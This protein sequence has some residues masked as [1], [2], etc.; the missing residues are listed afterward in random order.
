MAKTKPTLRTQPTAELSRL[1]DDID[2]TRSDQRYVPRARPKKMGDLVAQL[3][4]RRG[5]AQETIAADL[6][7]AWTA[8]A[9]ESVARLTRVGAVRRGTLEVI[10]A[11]SAVSQELTFRKTQ[12]LAGLTARLPEHE[13][14][15]I[16]FR[17]GNVGE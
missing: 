12:L 16:R 7:A 10:V 17:T 3:L 6:S 8:A 1:I 15:N 4:A 5:Y 9:G 2:R 13:I 11:N 14:K